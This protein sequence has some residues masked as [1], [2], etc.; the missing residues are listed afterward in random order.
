MDFFQLVGKLQR[1]RRA[2]SPSLAR[3]RQAWKTLSVDFNSQNIRQVQSEQ[4]V[5][6][7]TTNGKRGK[8]TGFSTNR[9]P[10]P[11]KYSTCD[12]K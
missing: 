8:F 5:V 12:K 11:N 1:V 2:L 7:E 3:S 10:L 6:A 4:V 9:R